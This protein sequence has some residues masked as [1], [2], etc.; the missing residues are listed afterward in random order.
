MMLSLL[1]LNKIACVH[2][3]YTRAQDAESAA[4]AWL[5]GL[6]CDPKQLWH[7]L[8]GLSDDSLMIDGLLRLSTEGLDL[9]S[10]G[11]KHLFTFWAGSARRHLDRGRSAEPCGRALT[12][13]D[14]TLV[15]MIDARPCDSRRVVGRARVGMEPSR[16]YPSGS[17]TGL[18]P[19]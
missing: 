2:V 6:V 16:V 13:Y 1:I 10:V 3:L 8:G 4:A 15:E 7:L 5:C 12:W 9:R 14:R 18:S 19:L 11:A 17:G